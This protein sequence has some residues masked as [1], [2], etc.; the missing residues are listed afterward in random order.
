MTVIARDDIPQRLPERATT[1]IPWYNPTTW[2][3]YVRW[4]AI[5]PAMVIAGAGY[6]VVSVIVNGFASGLP[7]SVVQ[8]FAAAV[9]AGIVVIAGAMIAPA[10]KGYV[11][12]TG[13][14]LLTILVACIDVKLWL[15]PDAGTTS[16][17]PSW[18]M[19]IWTLAIVAGAI[20]AFTSVATA[21]DDVPPHPDSGN[22]AIV[23]WIL[24]LPGAMVCADA[25]VVLIALPL[26]YFNLDQQII[27]AFVALLYPILMIGAAAKIAPRGKVIVGV[28]LVSIGLLLSLIWGLSG[29]L[30][31]QIHSWFARSGQDIGFHYPG[32]SQVISGLA[33]IT[34][35][36]IVGAAILRKPPKLAP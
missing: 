8:L 36:L 21:C 14:A 7:G 12:A 4:I 16:G 31:P 9:A 19:A 17:T 20:F 5:L 3:T 10:Y 32:W 15:F 34:G 25:I 26:V 27:A 24:F 1:S 28:T 23:R 13:A 18:Y 29:A 2:P 22:N 33:G 35:N 6:Y 30:Q 11:A